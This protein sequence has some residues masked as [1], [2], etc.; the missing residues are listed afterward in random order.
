MCSGG[1]AAY[2]GEGTKLTVLGKD[3]V[4][5]L[6]KKYCDNRILYLSCSTVLTMTLAAGLQRGSL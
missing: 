1:Y 4:R 6:I 5:I 2:F 3:A